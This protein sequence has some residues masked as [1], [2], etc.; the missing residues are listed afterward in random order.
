[1]FSAYLSI[2]GRES[3]MV[4][5]IYFLVYLVTF[6]NVT[7]KILYI[8]LKQMWWRSYQELDH[9]NH[10]WFFWVCAQDSFDWLINPSEWH[11]IGMLL[12]F[13]IFSYYKSYWKYICQC[14][15]V[16]I[17]STLWYSWLRDWRLKKTYLLKRFYFVNKNI[18][19]Y[20]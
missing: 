19:T 7:I 13:M 5:V 6:E 1:M 3:I 15:Y 14:I 10:S 2:K 4:K 12:T 18:N 11:A 17:I 16:C 8:T 9:K 20:L